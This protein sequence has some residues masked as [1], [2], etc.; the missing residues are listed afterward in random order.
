VIWCQESGIPTGLGNWKKSRNLI[1][2]EKSGKMQ[3]YMESRGKVGNCTL[4]CRK[5]ASNERILVIFLSNFRQ[6]VKCMDEKKN[7]C[8]M[9]KSICRDNSCCCCMQIIVCFWY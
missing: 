8:E 7:C 1:S 6:H 4:L 3:N 2:R 5:C 9:V